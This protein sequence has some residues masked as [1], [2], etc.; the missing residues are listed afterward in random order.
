MNIFYVYLLISKRNNKYISYVGYTN[1][2]ENRLKLHNT[3]K[4]A[5]FTKGGIWFLAY[6]M[7][8]LSKS[9]AMKE[10]YLLKHDKKKRYLIKIN[11]LNNENYNSITL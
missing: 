4:G 11:F 10:E 1:N 8:Y 6:S 2:L 7:K 9:I 3:S 5:K